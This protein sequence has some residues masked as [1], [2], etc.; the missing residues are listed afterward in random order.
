MK[1]KV[2]VIM[3]SLNVGAYIK[4]ALDSVTAQTL[5]EIEI[6][7]IDAGST[8]GTREMIEKCAKNDNRINIL[9]SPIKSYGRQVNIGISVAKGE[10]LAVV[11]TDDYIDASMYEC[12]YE[13][14]VKYNLD[15]VKCDYDAYITDENG[16]RIFTRRCV[17]NNTFFYENIFIPKDN[18]I[19]VADD[20]YLWNGIYKNSFL[21]K[22]HI[23]F[24]ETLGAAF[25]DIGFLHKV[26]VCCERAKYVPKSFYRYCTDRDGASSN[27]GRSLQFL[28]QE[29]GLLVDNI[30]TYDSKECR[31]LYVRMARAFARA[32]MEISEDGL[33]K[34]D[35]IDSCKWFTS[36]LSKAQGEKYLEEEDIPFSLKK[37]YTILLKSIE[38]YIEYRN[39]RKY[40]FNKCLKG[41]KPIVI[42]G[43]GIFGR[44][45][46]QYI[47]RLGYVVDYFMDNSSSTW[48]TIICGV[49]VI[50]PNMIEKL[51][52]DSR[53]IVANEKH[54]R[55]IKEQIESI[56]KDNSVIV[57]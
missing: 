18:P 42:F 9:D 50:S 23:S 6:I 53:F 12:L 30:S 10:Y 11:E 37:T 49:P 5:R 51:P 45:A 14:A 48:N 22:N 47:N 33:D 44:E 7:C 20:S 19:E 25:Q 56:R 32:C 41:H 13:I 35:I 38:G 55:E 57:Y 3:P 21:K 8:D 4:E 54:S 29:Y 28:R 1:P 39:N 31:L 52:T 24:S 2:S 16:Q 26:K 15:Y 17:S 36:I 43:C 34:K 40:E 46:L 27:T